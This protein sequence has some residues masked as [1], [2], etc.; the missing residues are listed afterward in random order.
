M[1]MY[2]EWCGGT[3]QNKVA[4]TGLPTMFVVSAVWINGNWYDVD[5]LDCLF[6]EPARI[7]SIAD[8]P[9]YD[10]VIDFAQ[11][12]LAQGMLGD[13]T[14]AVELRCPAGLALGREGVGEGVV[15]RCLDEPGSDYWFKVKGQ[16]HSASRVTKLAAVS[17]E[18]IAKT[19]DFV[20]MAVSEARLSQGLHNLIYEQRKPFDMSGMADFIR[21][22]VG[23]VMKEEADTIS[24]NG[25]DARKLG[26]PIAAVAR[27]WYCA[28]LADAAG[29]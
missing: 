7:R 9:Q 14:R 2:G 19:S 11:P 1:V 27:R 18:K 20:A 16:K 4:L 26:E 24:A 8:F 25:F 10:M 17:V 12:A 28:Q 23:D 21:W 3:I 5:T 13:I 15:W 22:V 29:S 6:S